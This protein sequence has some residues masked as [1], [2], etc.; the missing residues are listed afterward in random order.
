MLPNGL[1]LMRLRVVHAVVEG[2]KAHPRTRQLLLLLLILSLIV[3]VHGAVHL[4]RLA[5]MRRR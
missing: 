4:E 5:D 1:E 2:L 3:L